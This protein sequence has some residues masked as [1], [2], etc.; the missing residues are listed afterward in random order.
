[1]NN[2]EFVRKA[3]EI[4]NYKTVY[5]LGMFG[6]PLTAAIIEQKARQL[7]RWYT[8]ARKSRL[9]KLAEEG[10]Y[11]G[12]DCVCLIKAILWGWCGNLQHTNGGAK[13]IS[14]GVPDKDE[15]QMLKLC[16]GVSTNFK[17]I[18]P[19]EFLWTN[20]HCGIYIGDGL[21]VECTPI[22][23]GNVQ[24]TA[25]K[26]ISDKAGYN[27]RLWTK[28][29]KLPFVEYPGE[30]VENQK[31]SNDEIAKEVINGLWGNGAERKQRLTAAGYSYSEIQKKVNALAN[32]KKSSVDEIAKEVING[33]WGNGAERK[34]RLTAAGYSYSEIQK[35]VN[36]L[37][38]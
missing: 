30:S 14:N 20:G 6:Q 15:L 33:L 19:G 10:G 22:W 8:P 35:R 24:I 36:E 26:N 9:L 28:H 37:L 29:G 27:S 12:F 21:A 11:F 7:P 38:S 16:A 13:Y 18:E 5:A 2:L 17:N 25:V 32:G 3:K 34:Q 23:A 31:K 4:T 1:M